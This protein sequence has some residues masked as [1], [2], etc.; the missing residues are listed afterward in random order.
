MELNRAKETAVPAVDLGPTE[1]EAR[2]RDEETEAKEEGNG[3]GA[4]AKGNARSEVI[5]DQASEVS[6]CNIHKIR[7]LSC[8]SY[9]L[10][11]FLNLSFSSH[12]FA[13]LLVSRSSL[14]LNKK[15]TCLLV[16]ST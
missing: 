16:A 12:L 8:S 10:F 1:E 2:K 13:L 15:R 3:E 14:R 9:L 5:H 4:A 11:A 6:L 7:I